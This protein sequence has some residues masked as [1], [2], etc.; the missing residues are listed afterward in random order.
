MSLSKAGLQY[1]SFNPPFSK[2]FCIT[3]GLISLTAGLLQ[4]EGM[5]LYNPSETGFYLGRYWAD[6]SKQ[7]YWI[8]IGKT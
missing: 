8:A 6:S 5:N 4:D 1:V 2:L 7:C 3:Y